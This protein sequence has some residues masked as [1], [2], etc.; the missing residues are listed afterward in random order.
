[1]NLIE[2][3]ELTKVFAGR[4]AVARLSIDVQAGEIYGFLG[5][6]GAGKTTTIR[7]LTGILPPSCGTAQVAGHDVRTDPDRVRA[8][9][10]VLSESAGYYAWMT[11]VEYL[12]FFAE[13]HGMPRDDAQ[14]RIRGLLTWVG[15]AERSTARLATFSRGMRARLGMAR[16]LLH[17]PRVVFLDEPTLGL[18]PVGQ[19]AV[20]ELI[21]H[22]NRTE[23]TTV[24]L[25]S[26]ALDQVGPLC[27]RVGI[28]HEG[29]LVAQGTA[30]ELS[31]RLGLRASL[32]VTVSDPARAQEVARRLG[33][34]TGVSATEAGRLLLT[35][36]N[37]EPHMEIL[38]QALV[39]AGVAVRDARV[40][41]PDLE[42]VFFA[43]V[44]R[45]GSDG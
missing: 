5:P 21:Q 37:G 11:P 27:E 31:R 32:R 43:L 24:F 10:G 28:M 45:D 40:V 3:S 25:S 18:D 23:G 13:L 41:A 39:H 4:A 33:G 16:A 6:N 2:T 17:R 38:V 9:I 14:A 26:H 42:D 12:G 19:R 29:R 8:A 7:L 44:T 15:L 22:V 36:A 34:Y 35:P 1:M 20:L 30:A